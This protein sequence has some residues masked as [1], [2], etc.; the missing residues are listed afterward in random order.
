MCVINIHISI[1]TMP[2]L[3]SLR[4]A[5][6]TSQLLQAKHLKEQPL[7][8]PTVARIP[9]S[10]DFSRKLPPKFNATKSLAKKQRIFQPNRIQYVEDAIRSKFYKEHPWELARPRLVLEN[11]GNDASQN[12]WSKL[13]QKGKLSG[14]SVVQRSLW[15][16]NNKALS[17]QEAYKLACAEFYALRKREAVESRIAVEEAMSY[18]AVFKFETEIGLELERKV[19]REWR[20]KAVAQKSLST[21]GR[22]DLTTITTDEK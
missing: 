22:Q 7:W 15:L 1:A 2:D 14:E 5:Q 10:T 17:K 9:P 4:V 8:L 18:G 16:M 6:T 3:R 12:D 20:V 11:T 13:Q 19:V 21:P